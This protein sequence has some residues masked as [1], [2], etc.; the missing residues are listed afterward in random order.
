MTKP[1]SLS[2][3]RK[4]VTRL[5][6]KNAISARQLARET[7]ISQ[8]TLSRWLREARR[9]PMMPKK[10][11]RTSKEW[12]V[13]GNKPRLRV[14][15]EVWSWDI[16][17]LP[18]VVRGSFYKLYLVLDVWSRRIVGWDVHRTESADLAAELIQR[19]ADDSGVD[20]QGLVLHADDGKPMRGSTMLA[21]LQSLG[22]VPSFSR[23]HVALMQHAA[24][25][26]GSS[27]GTTT[28]TVTVR[29]AT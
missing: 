6:G 26:R 14:D 24:G 10:K 12:T 29:S 9:L 17:W 22:V 16:T 11:S 8:E 4:M 7:G 19:I 5:T 21:T 20:L 2:F 18:T 27:T 25:S 13:E 23:P 1:F 15:N 28:S 3:K